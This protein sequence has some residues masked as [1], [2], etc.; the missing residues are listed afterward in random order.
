MVLQ[1]VNAGHVYSGRAT[2]SAGM[3]T[4]NPKPGAFDFR[5]GQKAIVA[6]RFHF[7]G[8]R[9]HRSKTFLYGADEDGGT[10]DGVPDPR[11]CDGALG[12]ERMDAPACTLQARACASQA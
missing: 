4:A 10:T 7:G 5:D 2:N 3:H 6:V 9:V 11:F 1:E 8:R 12:V